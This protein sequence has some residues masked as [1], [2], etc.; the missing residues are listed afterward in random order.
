LPPRHGQHTAE[1]LGSLGLPPEVLAQL[2][3]TARPTDLAP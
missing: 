1:V 3:P 2:L